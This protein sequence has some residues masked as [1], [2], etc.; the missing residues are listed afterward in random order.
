MSSDSSVFYCN[1]NCEQLMMNEVLDQNY[2]EI[3]QSSPKKKRD[4]F[5][6]ELEKYFTWR[7]D[8]LD[9]ARLLVPESMHPCT[10]LPF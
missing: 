10:L 2:I 9:K 3:T 1:V 6:E 5:N 8:P 4:K 7:F